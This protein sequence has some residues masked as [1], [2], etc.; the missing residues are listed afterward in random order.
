[1]TSYILGVSRMYKTS[2][3]YIVEKN[4]ADPFTVQDY[5]GP[6][7]RRLTPAKPGPATGRL[8]NDWCFCDVIINFFVDFYVDLG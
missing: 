7:L 4:G 8:M 2:L 3:I 5:R 1:M 6:S